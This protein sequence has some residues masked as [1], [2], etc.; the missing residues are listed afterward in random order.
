MSIP[1]SKVVPAAEQKYPGGRPASD[2][3]PPTVY[4]ENLTRAILY[5]KNQRNK[6]NYLAKQ[7]STH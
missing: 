6:D 5:N 3:S 1:I 4:A 7:H 2:P